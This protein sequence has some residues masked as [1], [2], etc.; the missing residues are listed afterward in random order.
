ML[1]SGGGRR[2]IRQPLMSKEEE[3]KQKDMKGSVVTSV[4]SG[5]DYMGFNSGS[6]TYKL[7]DLGQVT[8][9]LCALA[10]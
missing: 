8:H 10:F 9:S 2:G 1:K 4:W 5:A 6:T 3:E 7:C